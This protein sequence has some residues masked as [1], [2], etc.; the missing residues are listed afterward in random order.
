MDARELEFFKKSM[1]N[2]ILKAEAGGV[3]LTDFLDENQQMII[4]GLSKEGIQI[5]LEGG[6][7]HSETKRVMFLPKDALV[8]D[9]KIVVF[10]ILYQKRYLTLN[11]RKVLGS[12]MSLGIQRKSLGDIYISE[13]G[14]YFACTKEIAPFIQESFTQISGVPIELKLT[15]Q[16][17]EIQKEWIYQ[18][19]I[20]SSLRLDV[21]IA[22]AYHLSRKEALEMIQSG[23]VLL[24]HQLCLNN[25]YF[26]KVKDVL[27]VRHKG[28]IYIEEIGG[29][30]RNDRIHV[31]LGF[32]K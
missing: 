26:V 2:N 22:S 15:I 20:V 12:L 11:H 21:I 3:V 14:A 5:C 18:E 16:P 30:T 1:Q 23:L 25:S 8:K 7:L 24:N 13:E 32:L 6:L 28:R 10:E 31:R 29:K 17:I 4:A 19:A 27:S 9:F